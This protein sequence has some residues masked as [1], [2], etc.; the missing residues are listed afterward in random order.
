MIVKHK[1]EIGMRAKIVD[2][3]SLK[4]GLIGTVTTILSN[5]VILRLAPDWFTTVKLEHLERTQ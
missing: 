2:P 1:L 3:K 5:G 4:H